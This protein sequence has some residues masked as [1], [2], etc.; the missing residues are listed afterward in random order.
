MDENAEAAVRLAELP[1]A[2]RKF[3]AGLRDDELETLKVVV[4]LPADDVR[5][6]FEMVKAAQTVGKFT[7]WLIVGCIALFLGTVALW[8]GVIRFIVLFKGAK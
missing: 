4:E 7:K 6:G 1:E 8:E 3:L 5:K 2:T